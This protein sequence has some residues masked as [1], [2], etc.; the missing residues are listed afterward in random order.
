MRQDFAA[1]S[2]MLTGDLNV[3]VV[4][5]IVQYRIAD[6]Y[7]FLFRLLFQHV[8]ADVLARI[9]G[10]RRRGELPE[11]TWQMEKGQ[12]DEL[13]AVMDRVFMPAPVARYVARLVAEGR[14][15]PV[16][17][18]SFPLDQARAS[19]EGPVNIGLSH[20]FSDVRGLHAS[21]VLDAHPLGGLRPDE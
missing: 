12:L 15:K 19:H 16:V 9:I 7:R 8:D 18:K 1:E 21:A 10:E 17:D 14:L 5:W 2:T 13:F 3:A 20:D 4:E 6:A 11:P